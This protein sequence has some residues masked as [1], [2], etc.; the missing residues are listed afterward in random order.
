M[1][2]L[3]LEYNDG[4]EDKTTVVNV[5]MGP[6]DGGLMI[7][8]PIVTEDYWLFRVRL[9]KDQALLAFPK[10]GLLGVGFAIEEAEWNRNLP[11]VV[12]AD[13]DRFEVIWDHIK[14]NKKYPSIT[15][16]MV[17]EA[18]GL[19]EAAYKRFGTPMSNVERAQSGS[20][21]IPVVSNPIEAIIMMMIKASEI[22]QRPSEPKD[23]F[24]KKRRQ[25]KGRSNDIWS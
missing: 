2:T 12:D 18:L 22:P 21:E 1:K 24:D 13:E 4:C 16:A 9:V 25:M 3:K 10:I 5:Q 17:F 11:L 15:K 19:I 23:L 7:G 14:I 6:N 20:P 8:S